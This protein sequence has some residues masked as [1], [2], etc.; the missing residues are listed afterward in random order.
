MPR[1]KR[2]PP[3]ARC[4][5]W[6]HSSDQCR[7]VY[8]AKTKRLLCVLDRKSP[9]YR[10]TC[11]RCGRLGHISQKCFAQRHQDGTELSPPLRKVEEETENENDVEVWTEDFERAAVMA[12]DAILIPETPELKERK[13]QRLDPECLKC[14][15]CGRESHLEKDCFA[16]V[17]ADGS[18]LSLSL[19][20][21][22]RP[23]ALSVLK[24][25]KLE[26]EPP[27]KS[28]PSVYVLQLSHCEADTCCSLAQPQ[29]QAH[30]YVGSS[31]YDVT[32]RVTR[33][34]QG[35]GAEYTKKFKPVKWLCPL[36]DA[37][38]TD[39]NLLKL[40]LEAWERREFCVRV[41]EHGWRRVRGWRFCDEYLWPHQSTALAVEVCLTL[42]LC[43]RCGHKGHFA[44]CCPK[45]EDDLVADWAQGTC[46]VM[47]T[48][49]KD[50]ASAMF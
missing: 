39:L 36:S 43:H 9:Q 2:R 16:Q 10:M 41:F 29:T 1:R 38:S 49:V 35:L 8:H 48:T 25:L 46:G 37:P 18:F 47:V 44:S 13:R 23:N 26:T 21:L 27:T 34:C 40:Y 31:H 33:H 20:N 28:Q 32:F 42:N 17:H 11:D 24:Q 15:R 30:F 50:L 4:A 7:A 3:C 5:A 12:M 19:N 14:Q 45:K 22:Q 6:T